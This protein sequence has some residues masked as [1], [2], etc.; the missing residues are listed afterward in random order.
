[1]AY[2]PPFMRWRLILAALGGNT[3]QTSNTTATNQQGTASITVGGNT[4]AQ[5]A[6]NTAITQSGSVT[7]VNPIAAATTTY[8]ATV[9]IAN[10]AQVI[11][12]QPDFPRKVQIVV[13]DANS[14]ITVG[15]ITIVGVGARGQ[16][17]NQT[18]DISNQG[19]KTYTTADAYATITSITV[20]NLAGALAGSDKIAAGPTNALGLPAPSAPTPSNFTVYKENLAATNETVGTVD[21]TAGTVIPSTP[22]DGTKT[23]S[24]WYNYQYTPAQASHTHTV[25]AVTA[26][27]GGHTHVQNSHAHTEL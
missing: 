4:D 19:T 25:A 12:A 2:Q 20:A 8:V 6:T 13:T 16:A 23:F 27:D 17:L 7:Y 26:T 11:A 5:T 18:F 10:A 9:D 24:F 15:Q 1:M 14:S 22:P 21:A 3:V